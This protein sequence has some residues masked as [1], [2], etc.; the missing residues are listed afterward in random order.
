MFHWKKLVSVFLTGCMAVSMVACGQSEGKQA[1][2]TG[3]NSSAMGRY[4]ETSYA[5]SLSG[6]SWILGLR[7]GSDGSAVFYSQ[8]NGTITRNT[9]KQDGSLV[10]EE[11]SWGASVQN[12]E[13][14]DIAEA[15]D[16]TVYLLV[17]QSDSAQVLKAQ[18]EQTECEVLSISDWPTSPYTDSTP[19]L[20]HAIFAAAD[21][22]VL[23][24]DSEVEYR[25]AAGMKKMAFD[26]FSYLLE[27]DVAVY[28]TMIAVRDTKSDSY[29]R[30][31]L[32]TGKQIGENKSVVT[33]S[34]NF[35]SVSS[36]LTDDSI[37][38]A[39]STGIYRQNFDGD[40]WEQIVSGEGVSMGAPANSITGL[41]GDG[42]DGYYVSLNYT[43]GANLVYYSYSATTP[44]VPDTELTIYSLVDYPILRQAISE[45]QAQN[46]NVLVN[47]QIPDAQSATTE[48]S[49]R[50]L[51]TEILNGKG[52]DLLVLD[53]LPAQS[54]IEK[55]V[56]TNLTDFAKKQSNLL[57]NIV[58][59]MNEQ[60]G[61][62]FLP[63]Q[64]TA[65]VMIT[66]KSDTQPESL[67]A[68]IEKIKGNADTKPYLI[69]P[70][71]LNAESGSFLTDW[72]ERCA[73]Q[74]MSGASLDTSKLESLFTQVKELHDLLE[75]DVIKYNVTSEGALVETDGTF[76]VL[77]PSG[78]ELS[79]GGAAAHIMNL[80]GQASL[81]SLLPLSDAGWN[82]SSL[83]GEN[84][85]KAQCSMG[86][87]ESSEQKE[88]AE[89]F[90]TTL[91]GTAVQS[92]YVGAGLPVNETALENVTKST[93]CDKSG[94]FT[95]M[96]SQV[97]ELCRSLSQPVAVD[98]MLE[99]AISEQAN[100]LLKGS[101]TPKQ[102]AQSVADS[103]KLYLAE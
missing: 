90:L 5:T 66:E 70:A 48:D 74:L 64:F 91:F 69:I 51:N 50:A 103:V 27:S 57:K 32:N 72:Y 2:N 17:Y 101:N 49:I 86:I 18:P 40:K 43:G 102:A 22:F 79:Q 19:Y 35:F 89:K 96:G 67:S 77:D 61:M 42:Q 52:P 21:G 39:D 9:S 54:Y 94:E 59:G 55:G 71:N 12:A 87:L 31:D 7:S 14:K 28:G 60:N 26:G 36:M 63:A 93:L 46:P 24:F 84:V 30:Y 38:Y 1:N 15:E 98:S 68:L 44:S 82:V 97:L 99:S 23:V 6:A 83:F 8:Q 29:L 3:S 73:P 58:S 25:D 76:E 78:L 4:I 11:V 20:P 95:A 34:D 37:Y 10:A 16:G 80:T 100:A 88:L 85:F 65:S 47:L 62:Y 33:D 56:L 53:G 13:I 45:F 75:A 81:R 41:A 92:A